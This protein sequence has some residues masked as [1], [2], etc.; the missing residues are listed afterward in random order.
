MKE[1]INLM[2]KGGQASAGPPLG[3]ALGG[4]GINVGLVVQTIN[5]KTKAMAGMDV[6]VKV[7]VDIDAKSFE[8]TVGLPPSSA[9][10]LKE[11][12]AEKGSGAA[13][14]K[15]VST[16][17]I[18]H[19]IKVAKIKSDALTG[20]TMKGKILELAGTCKS[21]GLKLEGK[22]PREVIKEIKA[23][24]YDKMIK[25]ERT[26]L[27]VEEKSQL[28][29]ERKAIKEELAKMEAEEKA[30]AEAIAQAA[31]TAAATPGTPGAPAVAAPVATAK[32]EEPAAKRKKMR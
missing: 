16:L 26:E 9:L 8:I 5:E 25:E 15:I 6:P 3:P 29:V 30:A 22:D 11:A 13:G 21:L 31:P 1:T 4:K 7:V 23:G 14:T 20:K 18:P 28:D 10:L 19:L 12:A 24:T 32:K 17:K 27:T 2:V